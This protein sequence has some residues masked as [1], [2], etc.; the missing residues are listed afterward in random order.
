MTNRTQTVQA[1]VYGQCV[2][3]G[4]PE[5]GDACSMSKTNSI[6]AHFDI[7]E[8]DETAL[9]GVDGAWAGGARMRKTFAEGITGSSA[10]L[11]ISSGEDEGNRAY[12]AVERITGTLPD[13][14]SGSFTVQ[15]GGLESNP[16]SWFG[17]IVPDTGTD[18][19]AG[20][21]GAATI[22]HDDTGAFFTFV[23]ES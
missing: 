20:I 4:A 1:R 6:I 9:P 14:R 18:D 13:G 15:H 10:G 17:Y 8:W 3:T 16:D 23:L 7:T 21:T 22:G 19:L 2:M 11:F 5:Q 12:I